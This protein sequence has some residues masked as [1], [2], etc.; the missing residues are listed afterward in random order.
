[1]LIR[2]L[3]CFVLVVSLILPG[4]ASRETAFSGSQEFETS[5][6]QEFE[7]VDREARNSSVLGDILG[8]VLLLAITVPLLMLLG[9]AGESS[10]SESKRE[11]RH[12]RNHHR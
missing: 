3:L 4:C 10:K 8:G 7:S 12:G 11:N 9:G 5:E 1:M 2:R 6:S